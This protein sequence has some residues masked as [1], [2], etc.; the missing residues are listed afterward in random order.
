VDDT[1]TPNA[2]MGGCWQCLGWEALG[3]ASSAWHCSM[4]PFLQWPCRGGTSFEVAGLSVAQV[5]GPSAHM[6]PGALALTRR[7]PGAE[8]EGGEELLD[9]R[10]GVSI[11]VGV[12]VSGLVRAHV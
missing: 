9:L 6:P 8:V 10:G 12:R 2:K 3:L 4:L 1:L 5:T 11:V 7:H